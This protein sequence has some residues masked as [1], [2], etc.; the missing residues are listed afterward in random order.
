[1]KFP[2]RLK[3][4]YIEIVYIETQTLTIEI[5]DS[6]RKQVVSV[7]GGQHSL[8]NAGT[9]PGPRSQAPAQ[10]HLRPAMLTLAY[11]PPPSRVPD[12]GGEPQGRPWSSV[13][14]SPD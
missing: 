11:I 6:Q 7:P 12:G 2:L 13:M 10:G 5:P 1:M 14:L 9:V 4:L 3:T 8:I